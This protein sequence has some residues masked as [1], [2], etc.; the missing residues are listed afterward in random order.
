M[1]IKNLSQFL[2][3]HKVQET[4]NVEELK[5][6]KIA[7]DTPLYLYK[8][9][10]QTYDWLRCF[11]NFIT[12]LRT[13]DIHPIFIF[14]GKSPPEKCI[15]QD[16]RREQKQKIMEKTDTI[17]QDLNLYI[18][19]GESSPF[20]LE[21]FNKLETKKNK[22]LL[23]KS[24]QYVND[25]AIKTLIDRRRMYEVTITQEDVSDLKELLSLMGIAYI[26][27]CGE[28]E[29]D[30]VTLFHTG[31]V[32]YI[33]SGDTDVLAYFG[34]KNLKV[35]ST[36]NTT[37]LTF[38]QTSK[39]KMLQTLNLSEDSF[40]DFCIMCGTDYNKNIFRIGVEK[41]YKLIQEYSRIENIPLDTSIL[42]HTRVREIFTVNSNH[43]FE[44]DVKWCVPPSIKKLKKKFF[45]HNLTIDINVVINALTTPTFTFCF[46]NF[47]A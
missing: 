2:K 43:N 15:T 3:K 8:F 11:V 24:N 44:N 25:K 6:T 33:L 46:Q 29:T 37:N 45:K 30:C 34:T 22:S 26:Q 17:E 16:Y 28:A 27:S 13:W 14:E 36:I 35:I 12:F 38:I 19:T 4:L 5:Y 18:E 47:N 7:I 23:V 32:D 31:L 41:S 39:N 20:L 21:T 1:G 10:C 40:R 42:N 9:K